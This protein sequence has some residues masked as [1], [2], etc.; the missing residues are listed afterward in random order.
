MLYAFTRDEFDAMR[1]HGPL[2]TDVAGQSTTW[3]ST[4]TVGGSTSS[5]NVSFVSDTFFDVLGTRGMAG[6]L[7]TADDERARAGVA[8]IGA[9]MWNGVFAGRI[10][11]IGD[12]VS[13]GGQPIRIVGVVPD[14]FRG[15]FGSFVVEPRDLAGAPQVWLPFSAGDAFPAAR[16]ALTHIS[17]VA[18]LA[19]GVSRPA[20]AEMFGNAARA[21]S[22]SRTTGDARVQ[23]WVRDVVLRSTGENPAEV[24]A[25]CSMFLA[26]PIVLLAIGCANVV[27]LR[28][29][30]ATARGQ[31]WAIR[32]ALG[33]TERDVRRMLL[34][35]TTLL[36]ALALGVAFV[37]VRVLIDRLAER[38]IGIPVVIDWR[39]V[40]AS[41]AVAAAAVFVSGSLPA[42]LVGRRVSTH[43]KRTAQAGGAHSRVRHALVVTQV[44]LSVLLLTI[45]ALF[46]RAFLVTAAA[47]PEGLDRVLVASVDLGA[48]G[49]DV[50]RA[51]VF[52][53][54]LLARLEAD[55]RF[56][57][58]GLSDRGVFTTLEAAV[59]VPDDDT[60]RSARLRRVTPGWFAAMDLTA[61]QGR[62]F[63]ATDRSG[64]VIVNKTMAQSI[65]GQT[66]VVG[67]SL[68]LRS[69]FAG[70]D[71]T[72][73]TSRP[74]QIVGVVADAI[75][76]P[77]RPLE[78]VPFIYEPLWV[79]EASTVHIAV[80][81]ADPH[82]APRWLQQA[83]S[84]ADPDLPWSRIE[85]ATAALYERVD[86]SR[87]LAMATGALGAAALCLA[88]AGLFAVLSYGVALRTREI[89]I[90]MALGA[91]GSDVRRLISRQAVWLTAAGLAVGLLLAMPLAHA[92]RAA[93]LGISPID[94][95]ALGP[96]IAVLA[97]SALAASW[98]P[99]RRAAAIDPIRTLRAD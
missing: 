61:L 97:L 55:S 60:R 12:V 32:L 36:T 94:P 31:E 48:Q 19:P 24:A 30:R 59:R 7:L 3:R 52:V 4:L 71:G 93:F 92:I 18:R 77:I 44:A 5:V 70:A 46:T 6:R 99:A 39:V 40:G 29:A 13:L 20:A 38:Y 65:A 86:P 72:S 95:V 41:V 50:S 9:A 45:G 83:L 66:S 42:R 76:D 49:Y 54:R 63:D 14:R 1:Q 62:L 82:E 56:L 84:S 58:V 78:P 25:M 11:A 10:D 75:R 88:A 47:Q 81:P 23:I 21:L 8:V 73:V 57:A 87:S 37:G 34:I 43:L 89:G 53:D 28:I 16:E 35:E 26:G 80:L 74:V 69:L 79:D 91:R 68:L 51:R 85:P 98:F 64:S 90:R 15:V 2:V 22:R 67:R 33:A 17:A 27:N 96:T